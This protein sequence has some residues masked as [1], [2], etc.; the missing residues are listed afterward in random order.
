MTKTAAAIADRLADRALAVIALANLLF[1]TAFM[2]V[3]MAAGARAESL[4]VCAGENLLERMRTE[5]P[6]GHAA[7]LAEAAKVR[8]GDTLLFRIEKEGAAPSFLFGTMHMTDP[9]VTGLTAAAKAA[10][11][12]AT[13]VAIETTEILDPAKAQMALFSKPELTMFTGADRLSDYLDADDRA[14]LEKG[15]A[16]RGMQFALIER[17]KPWLVSGMVAMPACETAR[18][19]AGEDI[20]DIA[21][22]RMAEADGKK[23]VGLETIVE[24]FEAMASLPMEF[25]VKGLVETVAL[26]DMV[27]DVVETMLA[28]YTEGRTGTIWPVLQRLT[29]EGSATLEGYADFEEALIH[30]R[31]RTMAERAAPLLDEGGAFI[32]VGAL[33]LP[34]EE[35]LAALFEKAGYTVTPVR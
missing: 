34:G 33:H 16:A 7:V 24:Q 35:G 9:R 15:L 1:V 27:D 10:F 8:F 5:D 12:T 4:P 20:L 28:L 2:L 23:L 11:D 6:A 32:A 14:L 19:K 17:M 13:T 18:K 31:N 3:A 21:L 26:G 25:H 29:P 22:A 30:A